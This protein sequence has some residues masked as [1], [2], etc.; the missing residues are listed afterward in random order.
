M[1]PNGGRK[2]TRTGMKNKLFSLHGLSLGIL[3]PPQGGGGSKAWRGDRPPR[4]P[5]SRRQWIWLI[6]GLSNFLKFCLVIVISTMVTSSLL[7][8]ICP[9]QT[10]LY[11]TN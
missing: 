2:L 10:V 5:P 6:S 4:G 8:H 7:C 11:V 9:I 1:Y 3:A